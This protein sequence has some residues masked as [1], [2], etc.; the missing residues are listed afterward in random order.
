M[1]SGVKMCVLENS[2]FNKFP[3]VKATCGMMRSFPQESLEGAATLHDPL[4][5]GLLEADKLFMACGPRLRPQC[6]DLPEHRL[7]QVLGENNWLRW[8]ARDLT[9]QKKKL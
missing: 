2:L 8:P 1:L 6:V 9:G 3:R 5:P 4:H 7:G